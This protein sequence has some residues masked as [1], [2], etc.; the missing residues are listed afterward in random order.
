M[1]PTKPDIAKAQKWFDAGVNE[2]I[3][4]K[5]A[6][7]AAREHA[8]R[9]GFLFLRA[10]ECCP[11][12]EWGALLDKNAQRVKPRTVRFWMEL[13][14]AGRSWT[15]EFHKEIPIHK[16]EE[17]TVTQVLIMSPKP[18]IALLRALKAM[19]P[20]GEYDEVKYAQRKMLGNGQQLELD[21]T[22]VIAGFDAL[23]HIGEPNFTLNV[24][25]GTTEQ[26]ALTELESRLS[27]AL[28]KIRSLKTV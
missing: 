6:F 20:F 14:E 17:F 3:K 13:A 28:D 24:P 1:T 8:F 15:M 26:Q 21:F 25:Q 2:T 10:R 11:Q 16:V 12:G 18:L 23:D 5:S 9:S 4:F 22:K 19:R 27:R 7:Q